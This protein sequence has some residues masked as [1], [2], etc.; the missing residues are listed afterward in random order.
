MDRFIL[1]STVD[2]D[3]E[4]FYVMQPPD[5]RDLAKAMTSVP[6]FSS[7]AEAKAWAKERWQQYLQSQPALTEV[8]ARRTLTKEGFTDTDVE[9]KIAKARRA[10]EWNLQTSFE[11]QTR[12]GYRNSDDQ[13]VLRKTARF[14]STPF[15]RLYV[16]RCARCGHEHEVN[17]CDIHVAKCPDCHNGS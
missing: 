9:A 17:G 5:E 14:G 12:I 13:A 7:G 10:R 16:L 6:K 1:V 2:A 3:G 8:D 4:H 15:Q 11:W